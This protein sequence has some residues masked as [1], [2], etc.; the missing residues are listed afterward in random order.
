MI[1]KYK[2]N[3]NFSELID[4][5]YSVAPYYAKDSTASGNYQTL[6]PD[7]DYIIKFFSADVNKVFTFSNYEIIEKECGCDHEL[8]KTINSFSVNGNTVYGYSYDLPR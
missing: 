6:N 5:I 4:S 7:T 8:I 2:P 3:T 1:L